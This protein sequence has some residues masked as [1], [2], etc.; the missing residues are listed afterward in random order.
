MPLPMQTL[1]VMARS[2]AE[3]LML[4]ALPWPS[5]TAFHTAVSPKHV[6]EAYFDRARGLSRLDR[7]RAISYS[8][9]RVQAML[10]LAARAIESWAA[11]ESAWLR[12]PAK[13]RELQAGVERDVDVACLRIEELLLVRGDLSSARRLLDGT[14]EMA[15]VLTHGCHHRGTK[16]MPALLVLS[17]E[18]VRDL[19]GD[20]LDGGRALDR[21]LMLARIPQSHRPYFEEARDNL[22]LQHDELAALTACRGFE[23][24]CKDIAATHVLTLA[25]SKGAV[26]PLADCELHDVI[27]ALARCTWSDGSAVL[28]KAGR[29]VAQFAR[30]MRNAAAHAGSSSVDQWRETAVL[31]AAATCRLLERSGEPTQCIAPSAVTK[32][33]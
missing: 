3:A 8:A 20:Q 6:T 19:M 32:N 23:R 13:A 25:S 26:Q 31:A 28:D 18:C 11:T 22:L 10:E 30:V 21:D 2:Y 9:G 12:L 5:W 17:G 7:L 1:D 16:L 33:W 14:R 24:A 27:E 15:F 29:A 4:A